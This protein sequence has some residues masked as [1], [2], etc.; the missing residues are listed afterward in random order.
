V[1]YYREK[2]GVEYQDFDQL[3]Q[4]STCINDLYGTGD[5]QLTQLERPTTAS[6][7]NNFYQNLF[8]FIYGSEQIEEVAGAFSPIEIPKMMTVEELESTAGKGFVDWACNWE[9]C[10][11][12]SVLYYYKKG[13]TIGTVAELADAYDAKAQQW[14]YE[15]ENGNKVYLEPVYEVVP[16]RMQSENDSWDNEQGDLAVGDYMQALEQYVTGMK[17]LSEKPAEELT[18]EE[19]AALEAFN[20]TAWAKAN[21]YF[22]QLLADGL[23]AE[24]A[25]AV[26]FRM[27]FN[28]DGE[29]TGND[30]MLTTWSYYNSLMLRQADGDL[31]ITKTDED[32]NPLENA[33][34]ELWQI[35]TSTKE[36]GS[37]EDVYEYFYGS[38]VEGED[39]YTGIFMTK[40][41]GERQGL[42]CTLYT[43]A[44]GTIYIKFLDEE[45][46]YRLQETEA[47]EGYELDDTVYDIVIQGGYTT[48]I[49]L[50]NYLLPSISEDPTPE[51]P[52]PPTIVDIPDETPTAT[53]APEEN[54]SDDETP[55]EL[56]PD[57]PISDELIDEIIAE[58][59][60]EIAP[61]E[62]S[63]DEA[64][65][66]NSV[67]KTG[68]RSTLPV[69]VLSAALAALL[70][71]KRR[72]A[73]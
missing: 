7:Y 27:A 42:N 17:E 16:G 50:V 37:T 39:Y 32:G 22:T 57:E 25:S 56:T 65:S 45:G 62:Q 11:E 1:E 54:I 44:N 67:P 29:E 40:I 70:L 28:L 31:L 51:I 33:G 36:D 2:D 4:D 68:A 63:V 10:S 15:D 71:K 19:A 6:F 5:L 35:T 49:D 48:R 21:A 73:K 26:S 72:R 20:N 8:S 69:T 61:L 24:D 47:P 23:T 46:D 41:D 34:Y 43:D 55:L 60:E 64:V 38:K 58:I 13:E 53:P 66:L 18:E 52:T 59:D 14:Y 30:Y 12:E 3:L 9:G